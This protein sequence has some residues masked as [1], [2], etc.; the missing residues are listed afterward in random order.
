MH[1][2]LI[3]PRMALRPMD[4][5]Y[6]RVLSPS[7][8]L[9][10]LAGLTPPEHRVTVADE[11]AGALDLDDRPDLVGITVNVDTAHRAYA[12]AE[13]Y[14][15]RSVPVI[16]GGIHA[17]AMPDEAL[18]HA[19]A[20]CIGE[21]ELV[22]QRILSDAG[23][24]KLQPTYFSESPADLAAT[25]APRWDLVDRSRYLYTSIVCA[26]RGCP[27]GCEFCYN[28]CPYTH[29]G[30]RARP[31]ENVLREIEALGTRHVM[32]I[33]DN[34]IGDIAW[35]R[36][37][38]DAVAGRGLVWHAAVSTNLVAHPDLI[39]R[40]AESGCR[41]LFIGFESINA[42]S[43]DSAGKSQNRTVLY[44]KLIG[45]LHAHGIMV[46]ASMVFGFDHDHPDVFERSL[47][48]LTVSRV[49]TVTSHILTP[50]PGTQLHAKLE[51]QGR[52]TDR[53]PAHYNTAHVVF[54]PANMSAQQ[55][56]DGYLR[57]YERF[58]SVANILRRMPLAPSCRIPYL[59]F[60]LGYRRFGKV[61]SVLGNVGL[62]SWLGRL[63]RR[64]SYGIG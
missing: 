7:I 42:A 18:Q 29:K 33:D 53:D 47:E 36:R 26:T 22:W 23:C 59:L 31:V 46:N 57:F 15:T 14:R 8:S 11:N 16:M 13:H 5:E 43:I 34:F 64:L 9:L 32:F 56:Y 50:Y 6:K 21:A 10:V 19:D 17:S 25:P 48:W 24:G 54:R 49:E 1:I 63:A 61:T 4:S 60:N 20:V 41:S 12:I 38:A 2:K 27:F 45:M 35:T 62:M 37:F 58:Y 51:A 52:I 30:H 28:S 40:M 39:A 3:S 44:E 55:L